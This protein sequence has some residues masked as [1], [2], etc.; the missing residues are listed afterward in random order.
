[1]EGCNYHPT[2]S[3][4]MRQH[5]NK[6]HW[7]DRVQILEDGGAPYPSCER[8][9]MQLAPTASIVSH[10]NSQ[11]CAKGAERKH[12]RELELAAYRTDE[13]GFTLN[14]VPLT[15]VTQFLYL[16]RPLAYNNSDWPAL[17]RNLKKARVKWGMLSRLLERNG[18]PP[19]AR[20]MFYQAVVQSVLLY[21]CETWTI[22]KQMMKALEGFHHR[23]AL[24]MT[25]RSA[26]LEADGTWFY[27]PT[28]GCTRGS[29][30]APH[31]GICKTPAGHHPSGDCNSSHLSALFGGR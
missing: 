11:A 2:S 20:G 19:K 31:E 28:E 24:R 15:K 30:L 5:F 13:V 10:Q 4:A 6:R 29:R 21:G 27:P 16:G 17:Y 22:N 3:L 1:M 14:G 12:R 8:C 25:G 26:R 9:G 23:C 7:N 18:V